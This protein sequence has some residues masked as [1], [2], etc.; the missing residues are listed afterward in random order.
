MG[1]RNLTVVYMDGAYRVA[2]YGQ[3]DGYPEGNGIL[4]LQFLRDAFDEEKFRDELGRLRWVNHEK[5]EELWRR[6]GAKDN[7]LVPMNGAEAMMRVFPEFSRDT[8]VKI[9]PMIQ[10]G[11]VLSGCLDNQIDFAW[12][13]LMCEWV[14]LI[15][16]DRRTFEGYAGFNDK[17][18]KANDRFYWLQEIADAAKIGGRTYY[19]V[20]KVAEWSIDR[21][22]TEEEFLDAF[23]EKEEP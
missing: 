6:F 7:G 3:W 2:Q 13:G 5:L 14:W 1:T 11:Q 15:D 9:L 22:P 21:L 16:L 20:R 10:T 19:P 8:G 4:C 18:L 17:P 12:D 23:R